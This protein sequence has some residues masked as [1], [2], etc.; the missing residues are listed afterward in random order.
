VREELNKNKFKLLWVT[1]E[2][3]FKKPGP[4]DFAVNNL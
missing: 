4:A 2:L 3:A 1:S